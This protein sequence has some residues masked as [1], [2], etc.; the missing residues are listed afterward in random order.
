M[1]PQT[2][3]T[4]SAAPAR[5][6]S[7]GAPRSNGPRPMGS[8]GSR[9]SSGRRS[10]ADRPKSEFDQKIIAI[11]RV[12]R[13]V[14]GGRRM[15]FA[16]AMLIGDKKGAIGLGT[17]KAADTSLAIQKA[18]KAAQKH[19][20]KVSI[21]KNGSIA[22]NVSAKYSSSMIMIMPNKNRGLVAGSAIRDILV[23]A[24]VKHAT[25]K[26]LSG[27]KNKLNMAKA[28]LKALEAISTPH[29]PTGTSAVQ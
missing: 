4:Q 20:I 24:G 18:L 2:S 21:T 17:G 8:S 14:S 23:L 11:R 12:T 9:P 25:S 1:E 13:V 27:S 3:T 22:H 16:V 10:F 5:R 26:V 7:T 29:R 6:P 28:V 19:M 15:S